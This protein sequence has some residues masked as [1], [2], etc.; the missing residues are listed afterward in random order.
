ME[1]KESIDWPIPL[2]DRE[3]H[4]GYWERLG[5]T[6]ALAFKHPLDF[7]ER[8]P[9]SEGFMAP[10][11][12]VLILSLPIYLFLCLYPFMLGAM[13][14]I[15]RAVP[16]SQQEPPFHWLALG[17]MGGILVLPVLQILAIFISG[18]LQ[19]LCLRL[20][21]VHDPEIP[22]L[23]D[24]RAWIYVHG[25]MGL[26]AWTPLGPV[27]M[28]A[29][30]VVAGM[31]FAQMHRVPTWKGVIASLTHVVVVFISALT[32]LVLFIAFVSSQAK[33]QGR[34]TGFS[35]TMMDLQIHPGMA[36]ELVV[37]RRLDQARVHLNALSTSG[38]S[39]E[40]AVAQSLRDL[41]L[42]Y[43]PANSPY[44]AGKPAFQFGAPTAIGQ[45]G[46][47]PLHDFHDPAT[48]YQFKSGV[49]IEAWTREGKI[50]RYVT[51]QGR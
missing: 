4:P 23:H 26:A 5:S 9:K 3:R 15:S 2:E 24:L 6:L 1:S 12:F 48:R 35:S 25:F 51:F 47:T 29:V 14:L 38:I 22:Y 11:G 46:L 20:W 43:P 30:L 45:V 7:F 49:S 44:D 39:P 41:P 34:R 36:P 17:C 13:G 31:G 8:I 19:G 18:L 16:S 42:T 33:E 50:R 28:L 27:A 10:I 32:A 21:G 37:D 40:A